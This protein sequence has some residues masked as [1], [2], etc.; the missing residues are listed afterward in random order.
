MIESK[1][2]DTPAELPG[3]EDTRPKLPQ[4]WT[5]REVAAMCRVSLQTVQEWV[6]R[7]RIPSPNYY[8]SSARF[9]EDHVADIMCGRRPVGT[10]TV[11]PS[12]RAEIGK[13]GGSTKKPAK[14]KSRNP[15]Q[16]KADKFGNKKRAAQSTP[17]PKSST[18]SKPTTKNRRK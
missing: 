5:Y 16:Q 4:F 8:G 18:S 11:T 12:P 17:K 2:P 14:G 10:Y 6:R 7:G 9:T 1:P 15:S 3:L 13:L